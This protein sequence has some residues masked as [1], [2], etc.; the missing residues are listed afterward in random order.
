MKL[1]LA[2]LG[3]GSR[4]LD[5]KFPDGVG[6]VDVWPRFQQHRTNVAYN[7]ASELFTVTLTRP[8]SPPFSVSL[9]RVLGRAV[10]NAL[11]K[12]REAEAVGE[13]RDSGSPAER[14]RSS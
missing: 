10:G 12:S 7:A 8:T 4:R 14:S 5:N 6:D 1:S 2:E 9:S 11:M 3:A 13:A